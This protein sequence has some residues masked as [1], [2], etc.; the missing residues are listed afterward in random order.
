MENAKMKFF[1]RKAYDYEPSD[2]ASITLYKCGHIIECRLVE[3]KSYNL[4]RFKRQSKDLY[5]DTTTGEM[6]EYRH[7][8]SKN[9]IRKMK[10]SFERLRMIINTNFSAE[11]N[12]R[13]IVLT[14]AEKMEDFDKASLDF[15]RFWEKFVYHY[16]DLEYIRVIE[17]QQTGSWHIHVLVKS[18]EFRNL[19]IPIADIIKI[20]G[21]GFAYIS[22]MKGNDNVGA[23][24]T[25]CFTNL[26]VFEKESEEPNKRKCIIKGERLRFYPPNKKFYAC[27]R[28]IK[29]PQRINMTFGEAKEIYDFDNYNYKKSYEVIEKDSE[30]E[31]EKI[32]NHTM[33][34][35]INLKRKKKHN[36]HTGNNK[37]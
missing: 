18:T 4:C 22:P 16:S 11:I 12:E 6:R 26:D 28:G 33:R 30:T 3:R 34:I 14:Y 20:W 21:H 10:R 37:L 36:G 7:D 24:F 8:L 15:K 5:V 29:K 2:N 17:P 1:T 27:S 9:S 23:Y 35:Q 13:A 32:V 19:Y 31:A 25:A